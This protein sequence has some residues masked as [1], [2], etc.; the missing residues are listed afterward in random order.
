[1]SSIMKTLGARTRCT[2]SRAFF[3][4]ILFLM[5]HA[6]LPAGFN[7]GDLLVTDYGGAR[8]LRVNATS[9]AVSV[10][11]PSPGG[12][13]L[14]NFPA[15]IAIAADGTVYVASNGNNK[16]IQIDP[17]TGVQTALPFAVG[18]HPWGLDMDAAGNLFVLAQTEGKVWKITAPAGPSGFSSTTVT[19]SLLIDAWGLAV[20][21]DGTLRIGGDTSGLLSVD[22]S[23]VTPSVSIAGPPLEAV[24]K[25]VGVSRME[26]TTQFGVSGGTGCSG[27]LAGVW[28]HWPPSWKRVAANFLDGAGPF[29]CVFSLALTPDNQTFYV[30]DAGSFLGGS[31]QILK[32][33][34]SSGNVTTLASISDDTG[35]AL[36]AGIAVAPITVPE[37][38]ASACLLAAFAA[39][40]ALDEIRQPSG[41]HAG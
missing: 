26:S 21:A 39:L 38:G 17:L 41:A 22:P 37:P 23:D 20:Q 8:V 11:S 40:W 5:P 30:G 32:V 13:N 27:R 9:G 34:W 15:G 19:D 12:T 31:A 10:F 7:Q 35:P 24:M 3:A 29:H 36:P 16:V 28:Y 33:Q 1:M 6:A 4:L 2:G 14:L 18:Q 25:I